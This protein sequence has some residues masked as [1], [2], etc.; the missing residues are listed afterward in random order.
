[1][2]ASSARPRSA[3]RGFTLIELLV[4]L[5][6]TAI[7]F[8]MG[9]GA[10]NQALKDRDAVQTRQDRLTALETTMRV[11]VQ[12]FSELTPRPVRDFI[13]DNSLPCLMGQPGGVIAG[14][15]ASLSGASG[16][17]GSSFGSSSSLGG[18]SA[19]GLGSSLGGSSSSTLGSS[20]TS[21][22][23]SSGSSSSSGTSSSSGN[24]PSQRDLVVFT[25]AGWA[26]PAGIQRPALERAS[27]RLVNNT[28]RRMHWPVLDATEATAPVARDL[29]DHVKSVT[30]R[31]MT[32]AHQWTDQWPPL[33]NNGNTTLRLRPF[34]I[35]I[36]IELEDWGRIVRIVE[37]P[38]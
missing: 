31:Y 25:R 24:D 28:L 19:G 4:A 21:S 10:I 37:I 18:N 30:F 35:E 17:L 27:Y 38:T 22:S 9:Y 8:A 11:M 14:S 34:A 23:T 1:M 13:G 29:L 33:G 20:F 32:D 36:T 6:I 12:D 16:E 26:N 15:A 7:I 2:R 5:F 3:A